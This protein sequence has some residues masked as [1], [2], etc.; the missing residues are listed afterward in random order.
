MARA[1]TVSAITDKDNQRL[2]ELARRHPRVFRGVILPWFTPESWP[3]MRAV[4]ADRDNLHDTF[5]EFERSS[6]ASFN[7]LVAAGHAVEKVEID[8]DALIS[9]C[10]AEGRP[11]DG[12]ARQMFAAITLVKRD[13]GAGHA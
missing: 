6:T 9:W 13:K 7:E 10:R 2:R 11:L 12:K 3:K 8:A 1:A 4:A 5:E